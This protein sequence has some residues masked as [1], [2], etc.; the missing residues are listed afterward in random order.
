MNRY[1]SKTN[2]DD[3]NEKKRLCTQYIFNQC[4]RACSRLINNAKMFLDKVLWPII[5]SMSE[6][7]IQAKSQIIL[8]IK[9]M[10]SPV[11]YL[12]CLY[13]DFF[14]YTN[15]ISFKQSFHWMNVVSSCVDVLALFLVFASLRGGG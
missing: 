1:P 2:K 15:Y 9:L 7:S 10:S 5:I 6:T 12:L 3:N 13:L 8:I 14:T 4:T 11:S